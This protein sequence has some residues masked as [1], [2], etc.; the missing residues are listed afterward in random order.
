MYCCEARSNVCT[1]D[2]V[3]AEPNNPMM[4]SSVPDESTAFARPAGLLCKAPVT[5]IKSPVFVS[6]L[7]RPL[8]VVVMY[9]SVPSSNISVVT[10]PTGVDQPF[11][12]SIPPEVLYSPFRTPPCVPTQIVF[13]PPSIEVMFPLGIIAYWMYVS[14]PDALYLRIDVAPV[15][16]PARARCSSPPVYW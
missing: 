5:V 1:P 12:H 14:M 13:P 15:E 7:K 2:A 10:A 3:F 8:P 16:P 6:S 11:N 9:K 4:S